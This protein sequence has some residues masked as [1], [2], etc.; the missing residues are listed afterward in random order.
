MTLQTLGEPIIWP[1]FARAL[2]AAP[3]LANLTTLDA[4]GEYGGAVICAREAMTISHVGFR[5]G[6]ATGSPT[7]DVRIETVDATTGLPTGTLWATNTNIVTGTIVSNTFALYALTA[8]ASITAGQVFCVKIVYNSGTSLQTQV[9]GASIFSTRPYQVNNTGTP[10]TAR[11]DSALNIALGSGAA[12][13]YSVT[14]LRPAITA[15]NNT[16]SNSVAGAKRGLKFQ[17][18]FKCRSIGARWWG[19]GAVGDFNLILEDSAGSELSSSSTASDGNQY[20]SGTNSM[21]ESYF[22]NPVTLSPATDYRLMFEPT[23]AT[24]INISTATLPSA[25]YRA[26]W[27]YGTNCLYSTFTTAGGYVD[28]ATDQLPIIDLLL[29]Q[30]DDGVSVGGGSQRVYS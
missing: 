26:A 10:A 27:P 25:A 21:P 18:P 29:D 20:H 1:G 11:I 4:A 24:N 14:G 6:T 13:F 12:A 9:Y 22:D 8:S 30:L 7:A 15:T 5:C 19:N 16:F 17:V 23:S 3:S 2:T 28:T